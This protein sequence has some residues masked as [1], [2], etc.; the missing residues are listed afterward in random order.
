MKKNSIFIQAAALVLMM[1]A[2]PLTAVEIPLDSTGGSAPQSGGQPQSVSVGYVDM[3]KVFAQHPMTKR[4]KEEFIAEVDKR[5]KEIADMQAAAD[6]AQQ[7]IVSSQT[8][9]SQ[10]KSTLTVLRLTLASGTTTSAVSVSTAAA[11]GAVISSPTI[12]V[13]AFASMDTMVAK[14]KDIKDREAAI[15]LMQQNYEKQKQ[16][17]LKRIKQ[18]KDDLVAL[19]E[20]NTASVLADL[21]SIVQKM[22]DEE[23]MGVI[24]DKSSMLCGQT[25]SDMT[26]KVLDRLKGR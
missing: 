25:C 21:Y 14:E 5:K 12:N 1:S 24:F 19:E 10:L 15:A 16:E 6:K 3:D 22:A 9:V 17:I 18:N 7:V 26:Q 23:G 4:L 2:Y 11:S 8:E 13:Q 20:K